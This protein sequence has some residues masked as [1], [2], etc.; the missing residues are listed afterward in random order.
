MFPFI[1]RKQL[2]DIIS[3][4]EPHNQPIFFASPSLI[5]LF[6]IFKTVKADFSM[7]VFVKTRIRA[8]VLYYI[9]K[10]WWFSAFI[11]IF[12]FYVFNFFYYLIGLIIFQD[13]QK[14]N[15]DFSHINCDFMVGFQN[16]PAKD[17]RESLF[18][19]K[20]SMECLRR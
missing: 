15:P 5:S 7:L 4:E 6:S 19:K 11:S 9:T 14:F 16:N 18:E 17:T 13:L 2:Y 1:Y 20:K 12:L 3:K 8:K 10:V